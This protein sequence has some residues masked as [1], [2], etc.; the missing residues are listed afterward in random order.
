MSQIVIG[1]SGGKNVHID[2][3]R[4]LATR[5]LIQAETDDSLARLSIWRGL[6]V[7]S[8]A[9]GDLE[10]FLRLARGTAPGGP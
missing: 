5:L 4:L 8:A 9:E 2:I 3:P 6:F 10:A 1:K 7:M